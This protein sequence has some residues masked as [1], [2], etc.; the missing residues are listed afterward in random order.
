MKIKFILLI[1]SIALILMQFSSAAILSHDIKFEI[2][3]L[4]EYSN[5]QIIVYPMLDVTWYR[6][7]GALWTP[8]SPSQMW[9]KICD[10]N[11]GF[12]GK[13]VQNC[14]CIGSGS[15]ATNDWKMIITPD[16]KISDGALGW[17]EK[18][19]DG[20]AMPVGL[21][22][23]FRDVYNPLFDSGMSHFSS[24][25]I[26][27]IGNNGEI[28]NGKL[29][30]GQ[31]KFW[32]GKIINSNNKDTDIILSNA[33]IDFGRKEI[34]LNQY[35]K[36]ETNQKD[37]NCEVYSLQDN[38]N[39]SIIPSGI[40]KD[41]INIYNFE[42]NPLEIP[43]SVG[44]YDSCSRQIYSALKFKDILS[45]LIK[46]IANKE[47][48]VCINTNS[49]FLIYYSG[50]SNFNEKGVIRTQVGNINKIQAEMTPNQQSTFVLNYNLEETDP[51][52]NVLCASNNFIFK[53]GN[54]NPTKQ[55]CLNIVQEGSIVNLYSIG[56][57]AIGSDKI[58]YNT[59]DK[60]YYSLANLFNKNMPEE[61]SQNYIL[62]IEQNNPRVNLIDPRNPNVVDMIKIS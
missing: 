49:K 32:A 28:I 33:A 7:S 30:I 53:L 42:E 60:T 58:T 36:Y 6:A 4:T 40:K 18:N 62:D 27:T 39:Y 22:P 26:M 57:E 43:F 46:K 15:V 51:L 12:C 5:Q 11:Y 3:P 8:S 47:D 20:G 25:E 41:N 34:S 16:T 23:F 54:N 19:T 48:S 24:D 56:K 21:L 35:G 1:L 10:K 17:L 50:C 61:D 2:I 31:T 13:E 45:F 44:Y 38:G 59:P 14:V 52:N 29:K 55:K 9:A 37:I